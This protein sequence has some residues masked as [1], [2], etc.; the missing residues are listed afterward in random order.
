MARVRKT[1]AGNV[2]ILYNDI[3][4]TTTTFSEKIRDVLGENVTIHARIQ[5]ITLEI[6]GLDETAT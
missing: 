2:L 5:L 3:Q 6:T 1:L 4:G